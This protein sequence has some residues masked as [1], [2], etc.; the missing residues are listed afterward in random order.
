MERKVL[1]GA[2]VLQPGVQH[3]DQVVLLDASKDLESFEVADVSL[4]ELSKGDVRH[5]CGTVQLDREELRW[6]VGVRRPTTDRRHE[7]Q[8][9]IINID[10]REDWSVGL[11]LR[12]FSG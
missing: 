12:M 3:L 7:T 2:V 6:S 5:D 1:R 9:S 4:L 8:R 11:S 10:Y